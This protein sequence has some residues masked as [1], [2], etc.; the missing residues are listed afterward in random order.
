MAKLQ[1]FPFFGRFATYDGESYA[2]SIGPRKKIANRLLYR[3][4]D[5]FWIDR[6]TRAAFTEANVLMQMQ[7]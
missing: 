2:F 6:Q 5:Y 7:I 3:M 4:K 1:N